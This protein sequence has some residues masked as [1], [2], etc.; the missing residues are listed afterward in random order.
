MNENTPRNITLDFLKYVLSTVLI[1]LLFA[2]FGY[3]LV[4]YIAYKPIFCLTTKVQYTEGGEFEA[5]GNAL[6][7]RAAKIEEQEMLLLDLMVNNLLYRTPIPM[8][9]LKQLGVIEP[10]SCYTVFLLN[11]YV[12][13]DV[14]RKKMIAE[15]EYKFQCRMF[16]T[17][18]EGEKRSVFVLFLKDNTVEAIKEWLIERCG[19]IGASEDAFFGGKT[20][21]DIKDIWS[22]LKYCEEELK[23]SACNCD[24][25]ANMTRN[26]PGREKKRL[27]LREDILAYIEEHYRDVDLTQAQMADYFSISTYTLSRIFR[28]DVGIGFV[29]YVNAKRVEYA[30]EIL[31]TTEDSVHDVALKSGFDNDNNFYKVFKAN[32]GMSPTVF[33][34]S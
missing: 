7:E 25:D 24:A 30:K 6:D 18:L 8:S 28:N 2:I 15:T 26:N 33:R 3:L 31:L 17:D 23:G 1:V 27:K 20:V 12:L 14:E 16:V 19:E 29:T 22:C 32:V 34:E 4:L 10:V 21:L 9:K 13:S 5:I 11:G